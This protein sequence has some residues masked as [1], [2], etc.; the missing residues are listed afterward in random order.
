MIGLA[1]ALAGFSLKR[2]TKH[3]VG[4]RVRVKRGKDHMGMGIG[5]VG[6]IVQIGPPA[7]GIKFDG[8]SEVHKWYVDDEVEGT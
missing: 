5:K 7:L 2:E 8:M 3:R 6:T 1:N 4:D